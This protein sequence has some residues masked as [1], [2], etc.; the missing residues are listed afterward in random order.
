MCQLHHGKEGEGAHGG[1][2]LGWPQP[3]NQHGSLPGLMGRVKPP[4]LES[5]RE[6][7]G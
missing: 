5:P 7:D 4:S 2:S 6:E 1:E 3:C